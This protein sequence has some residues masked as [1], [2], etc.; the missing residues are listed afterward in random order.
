MTLL[1]ARDL[2]GAALTTASGR[3]S[4]FASR[5]A[6]SLSKL[7]A[8]FKATD[9]AIASV[10]GKS[11]LL[12]AGAVM[13]GGH[14]LGAG[15]D[16]E[17]AMSGIAAVSL[18]PKEALVDLKNQALELGRTTKFTAT[19]A[20]NGMEIMAQAGFTTQQIMSGIPGILS[21]SAAAGMEIAEVSDH[22]ASIMKGLQLESSETARVADVLALASSRTKSTIGSLGESMQSISPIAKQFGFSLEDAVAMAAK[23]QD[24]GI[25][26]SE[27]G[28]SIKTMLTKLTDPSDKATEIMAKAGV[29]FIDA[30]GNMKPP[31]EI[32]EQAAKLQKSMSGNA[33][34]VAAFSELVGLR[35][36]KALMVLGDMFADVND[37]GL[38]LTETLMGAKGAA[39]QMANLR[40]DN[41]KGD[42]TLLESAVDGVYTSMFELSGGPLRAVVQG[43]T[44]WVSANQKLISSKMGRFVTDMVT[45]LPIIA[46]RALLIGKIF[47]GYKA[48]AWTIAGTSLALKGFAAASGWAAKGQLW[49]AASSGTASAGMSSMGMAAAT[50]GAILKASML[51][52][53]PAIAAVAAAVGS[54]A[55]LYNRVNA[56][57]EDLEGSGGISGTFSRMVENKEKEGK[58]W[59]DATIEDFFKAHDDV[60]NEKAIAEAERTAKNKAAGGDQAMR[61]RYNDPN[62]SGVAEFSSLLA[63]I[64]KQTAA[65]TAAGGTPGAAPSSDMMKEMEAWAGGRGGGMFP[66]LPMMQE[67]KTQV[68]IVVHDKSGATKTTAK[69]TG[70]TKT[71]VQTDQSGGI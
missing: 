48:V 24:V 30:F 15:A 19:E 1:K 58:G 57:S 45:D 13:L 34:S 61:D 69:S 4:M 2:T 38:T 59:G 22:V 8:G 46:D 39:E 17:E 44:E 9:A 50:N 63:A 68:D 42:L 12:G 52:A 65:N 35:G 29:S 49:L 10:L 71:T 18:A 47:L 7:N 60:L 5:S 32:F 67:S 3:M 66:M 25:D 21:A 11:A 20:A 31:K 40:M 23:M 51:A 36:Q 55:L 16:F 27:A 33:A 26:A 6:R 64:E 54:L 62:F 14:V 37:E 56:L 70:P 43:T 28:N 41:L 53:L